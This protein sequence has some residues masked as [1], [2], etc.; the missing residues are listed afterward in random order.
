MMA[1]AG[2]GASGASRGLEERAE[3]RSYGWGLG[4]A[5]VLTVTPFALVHWAAMPG[6]PLRGL[7]GVFA[8]AQVIVHLRFFLQVSFG[9]KREITLL[10]LFSALLLLIMLAGTIW[11]MASLAT[12]MALPVQP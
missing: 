8:L 3:L 4:L 10:L 11:I 1:P 5:L 6:L 9:K 12:R 7:I 2:D